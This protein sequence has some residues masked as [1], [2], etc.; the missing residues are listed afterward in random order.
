MLTALG[1]HKLFAKKLLHNT[2]HVVLSDSPQDM[3]NTKSTAQEVAEIDN[4]G[5]RI[6]IIHLPTA[7]AGSTFALVVV[8]CLL[9]L[10]CCCC[11]GGFTK[12]CFKRVFKD[13]HKHILPTTNYQQL[14]SPPPAF[15]YADQPVPVRQAPPPP[16]VFHVGRAPACQPA[17]NALRPASAIVY[18]PPAPPAAASLADRIQDVTDNPTAHL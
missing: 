5:F 9:I 16:P 12:F 14:D 13:T 3:G 18:R 2:V 10:V 15:A 17:Y 8:I 11:R 1:I 4:D 7:V 6:D